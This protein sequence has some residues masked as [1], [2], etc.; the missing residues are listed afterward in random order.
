M[1]M[2]NEQFDDEHDYST[3]EE[4]GLGRCAWCK[5]T[6][7][8]DELSSNSDENVIPGTLGGGELVCECC[9]DGAS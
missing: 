9:R 4:N 5:E 6:V 7:D 1:T 2:T 3:L 8:E